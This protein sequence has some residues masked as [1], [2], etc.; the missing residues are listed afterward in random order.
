MKLRRNL[1]SIA[2]LVALMG[3]VSLYG[4]RAQISLDGA[5]ATLRPDDRTGNAS[6]RITLF[7]DFTLSMTPSVL[8]ICTP[9]DAVYTVDVGQIEGFSDPVTVYVSMQP[10]GTTAGFSVNPVFPPGSSILTIGNTGVVS[11]GTYQIEVTG[12]APT[13][14]HTTE[15]GLVVYTSVPGQPVPLTPLDGETDVPLPVTFAWSPSS[16][17]GTYDL[18]VARDGS[19][20]DIVISE[21]GLQETG[22]TALTGLGPD[23][24]YY[25]RVQSENSCGASGFWD[26]FSFTTR[27]YNR[28]YLPM[29]LR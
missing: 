27:A 5:P 18:Q 3:T 28:I 2:L 22:F 23:T 12:I 26:A 4:A 9:S 6:S 25:W 24:T 20:T 7:P 1:F 13:S 11:A 15:A 8:D 14:T 16:Q 19:F 21:T 29:M 10:E 17:G